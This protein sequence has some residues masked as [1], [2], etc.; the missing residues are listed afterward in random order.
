LVGCSAPG[1]LEE[2]MALVR[3]VVTDRVVAVEEQP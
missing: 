1:G 3:N 2:K